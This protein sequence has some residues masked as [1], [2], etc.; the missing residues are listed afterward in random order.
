MVSGFRYP[1]HED[2]IPAVTIATLGEH[3]CIT[4]VCGTLCAAAHLCAADVAFDDKV[5]NSLCCVAPCHI[6]EDLVE[7]LTL[8]SARIV[9]CDAPIFTEDSKVEVGV[10]R[11]VTD[12]RGFTRGG[13]QLLEVTCKT[14]DMISESHDDFLYHNYH[15]GPTSRT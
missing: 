14:A 4:L 9:H 12:E 13:R 3:R 7:F 5:P 6:A 8:S 10:D 15:R 1:S 11:F 2:A